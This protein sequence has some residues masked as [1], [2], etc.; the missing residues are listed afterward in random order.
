[1]R[2]P[3]TKELN[4]EDLKSILERDHPGIKCTWRGKKVLIVSEPAVSKSAAAQVMAGKKKATIVEA[5]STMGGQMA[6]VFS[7]LLLGILI[8]FMVYLI[9]YKP[10]QKAI[11]N[12]V[13]DVVRANYGVTE[14]V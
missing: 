1:M 13:A 14:V 6:F 5:F 4:L 10:K 11:C 7:I 8:P 2:V 12:K 9:A 3:I